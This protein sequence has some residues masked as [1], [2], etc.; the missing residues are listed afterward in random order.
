MAGTQGDTLTVWI[1][2]DLKAYLVAAAESQNVSVSA[3]VAQLLQLA[4]NDD[5]RATWL[6]VR[7]H[8]FE[9]ARGMMQRAGSEVPETYEE[10]LAQGWI[11]PSPHPG[12]FGPRKD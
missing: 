2:R 8:A 5:P 6:L 12:I 4:V 1:P 10:A 7:S 9:I 3:L 11:E